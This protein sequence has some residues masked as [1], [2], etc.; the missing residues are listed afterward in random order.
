M[1]LV[2]SELAATAFR[3][4][5]DEEIE[6]QKAFHAAHPGIFCRVLASYGGAMYVEAL[7]CG[8]AYAMN[9]LSLAHNSVSKSWTEHSR[10]TICKSLL[11]LLPVLNL[12]DGHGDLG[13]ALYF[14]SKD[15]SPVLLAPRAMAIDDVDR[16]QRRH[17]DVN[18]LAL[19]LTVTVNRLPFDAF[20][21]AHPEL[22]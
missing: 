1:G 2:S 4:L 15:Y 20:N 3:G 8:V 19:F 16:R 13:N 6:L 14:T 12:E 21:G 18:F 9:F 11:V 10:P 5:S 22:E 17:R 7:M